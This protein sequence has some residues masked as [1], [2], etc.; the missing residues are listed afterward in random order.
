MM[1]VPTRGLILSLLETQFGT[2]D[3][4]TICSRLEIHTTALDQYLGVGAPS[5]EAV[6]KICE[7]IGGALGVPPGRIYLW[8][9]LQGRGDHPMFKIWKDLDYQLGSCDQYPIFQN[10]EFPA[11]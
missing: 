9:R 11:H 1:T 7:S 5:F 6:A 10:A 4:Q 8:W 3:H 2:Q